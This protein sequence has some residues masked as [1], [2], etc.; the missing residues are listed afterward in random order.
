MISVV[1][2][3]LGFR[4]AIRGYHL[5]QINSD[6]KPLIFKVAKIP[7]FTKNGLPPFLRDFF[8]TSKFTRLRTRW[9]YTSRFAHFNRITHSFNF[10][11]L[12]SISQIFLLYF[13]PIRF[14]IYI[15]SFS[16][17][18]RVVFI[19]FCVSCCCFFNTSILT[20][21]SKFRFI[22]IVIQWITVS[23]FSSRCFHRFS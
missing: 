6:E 20:F 4:I 19:T 2:S 23:I 3:S 21:C 7:E 1:K 15:A 18:I 17:Y 22:I 12:A 9:L 5:I 13:F 10:I 11:C 16:F 14:D 8:K